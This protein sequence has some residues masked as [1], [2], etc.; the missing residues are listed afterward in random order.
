LVSYSEGQP[1]KAYRCLVRRLLRNRLLGKSKH[2]LENSIE[3]DLR[4]FDYE[5]EN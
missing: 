5:T 3:M 4:E 1:R 2:K